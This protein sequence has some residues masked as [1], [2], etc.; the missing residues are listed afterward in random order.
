MATRRV[1]V[2]AV[3]LILV[4]SGCR[5]IVRASVDSAGNQANGD[6]HDVALSADGRFV[7]FESD[8]TNLVPN[9]TNG[10]RDVFVRDNRTGAV[11]RVFETPYLVDL[12]ED[13]RYVGV[14]D[15]GLCG[16]VARWALWIHDRQTGINECVQ[17][18]VRAGPD[19]HLYDSIV[20][21]ATARFV[22][23]ANGGVSVLDRSTNQVEEIPIPSGHSDARDVDI[24]D[25]GRYVAFNTYEERIISCRPPP[26]GCAPPVAVP[27]DVFVH[28]RQTGTT[29]QVPLPGPD[30]YF[31]GD[32]S[33]SGD[34]RWV[35]Y[36]LAT[37]VVNPPDVSF[38]NSGT[39]IYDVQT[40]VTEPVSVDPD[41][42]VRE[43]SDLSSSDDGRFVAFTGEAGLDPAYPSNGGLYLRD[44]VEGRTTLINTNAFGTPADGQLFGLEIADDARYV[45]FTSLSA[46]LVGGD[47][48]G[49][50]DVFLRAIPLPRI[51]S[52]AP[53]SAARGK[54]TTITILGEGFAPQPTVQAGE[55][56]SV[57]AVTSVSEHQLS[58]RI[59]VS[60]L[61]ATGVRTV[62]LKNTG[63][64]P[65]P[66]AGDTGVCNSC[67]TIT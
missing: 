14:L 17:E 30:G 37:E 64:G 16:G 32:P 22:A 18:G 10:D 50:S 26:F 58:V 67:L 66:A 44:M 6:S 36:A 52:V 60:A 41:G 56:V 29:D 47:T 48:N 9:D 2:L 59:T 45:A 35:A 51:E 21:S 39:W 55:G 11:E 5:W 8:A 54:S 4:T 34:G 65:G 3:S 62:L 23:S 19:S 57:T 42:I 43:A 46:N 53:S 25:D 15:L 7:A 63:T 61:A 20:F 40:G 33:I 28:D 49:A 12:S 13:G 27:A 31:A 24:S 1:L 38:V